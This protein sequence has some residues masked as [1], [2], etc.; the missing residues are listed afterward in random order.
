MF[1]MCEIRS[2]MVKVDCDD[3]DLPKSVFMPLLHTINA[4]KK[5]QF[6]INI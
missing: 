5:T 3:K 1:K 4:L 6:T 2:K